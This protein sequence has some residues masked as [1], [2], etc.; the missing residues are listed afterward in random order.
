MKT[1]HI[2][3]LIDLNKK[4]RVQGCAFDVSPVSIAYSDID[5]HCT[6][7]DIIKSNKTVWR[8]KNLIDE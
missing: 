2:L 4:N 5:A 1:P 8:L 7:K 6:V 3:T